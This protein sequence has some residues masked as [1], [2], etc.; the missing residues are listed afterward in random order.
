MIT[1]YFPMAD[2]AGHRGGPDS[3]ELNASIVQMDR[4]LGRLFDEI[5][6]LPHGHLVHVVIVS[7]HGMTASNR[8]TIILDD[9]AN[10]DGVVVVSAT[11]L[12][13]MFFEGDTLRRAAVARSFERV[14]GLRVYTREAIP[15]EWRIKANARAGDL[16]LVADEGWVL[17]RRNGRPE[18][19]IASHGW[20]PSVSMRGIF[21]AAGPRVRA[22]VRMPAFENVHIYPFLAMLLGLRTSAEIDGRAEVLSA[23]L[24]GG[25]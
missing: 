3:P 7:D 24:R 23:A 19:G 2:D 17:R 6:A 4:A 13:S 18:S 22:G 21:L 11:T 15:D 1:L 25:R 9:H 12:A 16:L 20:A 10:L 5:A 8:G 14:A